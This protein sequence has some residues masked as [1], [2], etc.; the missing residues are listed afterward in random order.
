MLQ[1]MLGHFGSL[2]ILTIFSAKIGSEIRGRDTLREPD[3]FWTWFLVFKEIFCVLKNSKTVIKLEL[4][5]EM[6]CFC[7]IKVIIG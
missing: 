4:E 2:A 1:G 5:V 3:R 7:L 6:K